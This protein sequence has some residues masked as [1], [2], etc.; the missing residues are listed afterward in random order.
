V[1]RCR[2]T[3]ARNTS[4]EYASGT[5]NASG[6]P[7]PYFDALN[8]V[9][10][11]EP[12]TSSYLTQ[13]A[14]IVTAAENELSGDELDMVYAVASVAVDSHDY[15]VTQGG[16][17]AVADSLENVYGPCIYTVSN[18]PTCFYDATSRSPGVRM[19]PTIFR[20]VANSSFRS[21]GCYNT[22]MSAW[23]V[24]KWDVA[25]AAGGALI[26]GAHGATAGALAGSVAEAV[27]QGIELSRVQGCAVTIEIGAHMA[28]VL[29]S[30]QG[31]ARRTVVLLLTAFFALLG[32]AEVLGIEG[33][34]LRRAV[35]AGITASVLT[36][37]RS[38]GSNASH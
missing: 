32:L 4:S 26:G 13:I 21:L 20:S 8:L 36:W 18:P 9:V 24:L 19:P 27:S 16:L 33:T 28:E 22:H 15:W 35:V 3:T 11:A 10:D 5:A 14:A 25:G 30:K 2:P 23:R 12:G 29:E 34:L 31:G 6:D 17:V 1:L 38:R 37:S 7:Q